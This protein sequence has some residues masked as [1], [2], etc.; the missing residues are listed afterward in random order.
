MRC[1]SCV[2]NFFVHG[3]AGIVLKLFLNFEQNC[4]LCYIKQ[5][6]CI[7]QIG[8]LKPIARFS[9]TIIVSLLV[10]KLKAITCRFAP[11]LLRGLLFK[12]IDTF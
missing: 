12:N 1:T 8:L 6:S 7:Q 10:Y 3:E 5:W 9:E 4:V 11:P 2:L